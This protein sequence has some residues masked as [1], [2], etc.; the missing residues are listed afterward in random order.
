MSFCSALWVTAHLVSA[1]FVTTEDYNNVNPGVAL[2]CSNGSRSWSVGVLKNSYSDVSAY[3]VTGF[4][5]WHYEGFSSRLVVGFASGYKKDSLAAGDY[6]PVAGI[7]TTYT[8]WRVR[9]GVLVTPAYVHATI[10]YNF[11]GL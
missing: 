4:R 1:H 9:P 5:F 11:G 6:L 7:H 10:S 8:A 3:V 2:E